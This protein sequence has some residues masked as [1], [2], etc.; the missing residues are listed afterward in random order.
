MNVC[1]DFTVFEAM[2]HKFSG[3]DTHDIRKWFADIEDAFFALNCPVGDKFVCLRRMLTG[4]ARLFLRT[5]TVHTYE[6]LKQALLD[7]FG[8]VLTMNDV[9]QQLKSRTLKPTEAVKRY[10]LEM[11]EI[12]SR[13]NIPELDLIDCIVDGINDNSSNAAM[14]STARNLR[15]LKLMLDR[16]EKKRPRALAKPYAAANRFTTVAAVPVAQSKPRIQTVVT[17]GGQP[18][19]SAGVRCFN[20]SAFGHYRSQCPKPKRPDKACFR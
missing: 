15:D 10:V 8:R 1:F 12:A 18:T 2:T 17:G 3:D 5:S 9:F 6:A 20:C 4:T 14:L 19:V 11:Q 16:Y 13:A 7:E